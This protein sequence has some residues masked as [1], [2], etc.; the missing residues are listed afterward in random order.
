MKKILP[1]LFIASL[2]FIS[3]GEKNKKQTITQ[4]SQSAR[5]EASI[6]STNKTGIAT[7]QELTSFFEPSFNS[8]V[9]LPADRFAIFLSNALRR[10]FTDV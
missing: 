8:N 3:C 9:D 7:F 5:T 6:A 4:T 1:F 10:L 2:L